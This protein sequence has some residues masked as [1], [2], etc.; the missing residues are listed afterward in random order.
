MKEKDILKVN[1]EKMIN[2]V[3]DLPKLL[4]ESL[5]NTAIDISE[6][7]VDSVIKDGLFKDIPIIGAIVGFCKLGLSIRERNLLKQ[8][9]VFVKSFN[10][11]SID[12]ERL[13]KYRKEISENPKKAE[14]ELGRVLIILY[15]EVEEVRSQLLGCIFNAYVNGEIS[16]EKFAELSDISQRLF[17]EDIN[18]LKEIDNDNNKY[19][20][21][22][23]DKAYNYF[24]LQSLGLLASNTGDFIKEGERNGT[25]N[26]DSHRFIITSLGEI[27]IE[28][29]GIRD[30]CFG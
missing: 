27:F 5:G 7:A 22:N 26:L 20:V 11:G 23:T 17:I 18:Y 9:L 19:K 21:I 3:S 13:E 8:T 4:G 1:N 29:S 10:E 28:K 2:D 6:I 24:R 25:L 12:T 16:W 15:A 14:K 30:T